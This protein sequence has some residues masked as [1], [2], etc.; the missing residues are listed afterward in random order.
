VRELI[1]SYLFDS[2]TLNNEGATSSVP[3]RDG[4]REPGPAILAVVPALRAFSLTPAR[5]AWLKREVNS[6]RMN[7]STLTQIGMFCRA[8]VCSPGLS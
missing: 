4:C 8:K 1:C 7:D 5:S 3:W 2:A 6:C